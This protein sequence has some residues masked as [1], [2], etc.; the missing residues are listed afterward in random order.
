MNLA[1]ASF[2][3][4]AP[5]PL[6][7]SIPTRHGDVRA[8]VYRN[9]SD[10][11]RRLPVY[12]NFHGGGFVIRNPEQDH[13][14]CR[15]LA[16]TA[17]VV[18]IN[19][20]YDVAPEHP[21]PQPV[22]EA[23]D[24]ALW[25]SE[26]ERPWDGSRLCVGGQSAGGALAAGIARLALENGTPKLALQMLHYPALDLVTPPAQKHS[27]LAAPVLPIPLM[28]MFSAQYT[29]SPESR[30]D[31]LASPAWGANADGIEGIAPALMIICEYDRLHDEGALYA[32]KLDEAG[33]LRQLVDLRG[34]DHGYDLS[35]PRS[36]ATRRSYALIAEHIAAVTR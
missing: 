21:F 12:L 9:Q 29:P 23:Y 11:N 2:A 32:R 19:V 36:E 7:I 5:M 34:E 27:P 16:A 14:L 30:K 3:G 35:R 18:V 33:S 4:G 13:A 6:A 17:G 26:P 1:T 15:Y 31:R 8:F 24:V 20:D 28:D 10:P 22:E 25:A